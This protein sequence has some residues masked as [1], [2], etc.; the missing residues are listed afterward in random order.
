MCFFGIQKA[1]W[2]YQ[3][4]IIDFF[5]NQRG[6]I[7]CMTTVFFAATVFNVCAAAIAAFGAF[8]AALADPFGFVSCVGAVW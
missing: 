8:L 3:K 5:G 7:N 4:L 1:F 6:L 2:G